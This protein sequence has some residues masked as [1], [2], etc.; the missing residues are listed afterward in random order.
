M[1][2]CTF[3]MKNMLLYFSRTTSLVDFCALLT[4]EITDHLSVLLELF[5]VITLWFVDTI[6]RYE[7]MITVS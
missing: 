4:E 1:N 5:I 6:F 7:M 3:S 2:C